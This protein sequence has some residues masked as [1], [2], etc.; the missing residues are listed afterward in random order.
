MGAVNPETTVDDD[1]NSQIHQP[2]QTHLAVQDATLVDPSKLTA[3]SPEVVSY[4]V[5]G[6]KRSRRTNGRMDGN[7][8]MDLPAARVGIPFLSINRIS[9]ILF[10][11]IF[12]IITIIM[13]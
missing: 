10:I 9:H 1:D 12:T 2:R 13:Y 4:C 5:R 7:G 3:L 8:S 6:W 11:I